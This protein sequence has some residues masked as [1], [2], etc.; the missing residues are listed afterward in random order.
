M[1]SK[2]CFVYIQLPNSHELITLGKLKWEKASGSGVG[3]FVYGKSYLENSKKM[4]L[5]PFNLP[6]EERTF[7]CA[8][9]D[10]IIGPLRDSSPDNWGRTVI[11]KNTPPESHDEIGFLLNSAEDGVGALSFGLQKVPPAPLR[12]FNKTVDLDSLIKAAH[13]IEEDIP[14][15]DEE[16]RLLLGGISMGGARP[17]VVVEDDNGLWLAKFPSHGDRNNFPKIEYATMLMAKDC[18]LRVPDI[19]L[20]KVGKND[21][22]LIK[23]FD[24]EWDPT[25][26]AYYRTHFVS[27]LTL[28]NIDEGDRNRYSAM[29]IGDD[30]TEFTKKNL[31]SKCEAFSYTKK[32]ANDVYKDLKNKISKWRRYYQKVGLA[33]S[34]FKYL[35]QAFHWEGLDY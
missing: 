18:G 34:D 22:F 21:V 4:A 19:R 13:K 14:L 1:I 8:I 26:K 11:E 2:E 24:R 9:N 27:G 15:T 17:K 30:K 33:E 12:K 28:L 29:T 3:S 5:D 31:L 6:L 16:R 32:E 35:E 25:E 20:E 7:E 23:R 10:G